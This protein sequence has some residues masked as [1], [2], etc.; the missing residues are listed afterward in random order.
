MRVSEIS[1][2][3]F[4]W[5]LFSTRWNH[6][7]LLPTEPI[8]RRWQWE[9]RGSSLKVV[10]EFVT[11]VEVRAADRI[12]MRIRMHAGAWMC[13]KVDK[14]LELEVSLFIREWPTRV[15]FMIF[16]HRHARVKSKLDTRT[17]LRTHKETHTL[18]ELT[19]EALASGVMINYSTVGLEL[20]IWME[21]SLRV[22]ELLPVATRI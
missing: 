22:C 13:E 11:Q 15:L 12:W 6:H 9:F 2:D 19:G 3:I 17:H 4:S 14:L 8:I 20:V 7:V 10:C 18:T 21:T 5:E 1:S 16:A